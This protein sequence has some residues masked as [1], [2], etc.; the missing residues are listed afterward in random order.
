[1]VPPHDSWDDVDEGY[2]RGSVGVVVEEESIDHTDSPA[3]SK[4]VAD[5]SDETAYAVSVHRAIGTVSGSADTLVSFVDARVAWEYANLV[6]HYISES[7]DATFAAS[8]LRGEIRP[9]DERWQP[10]D[11]VRE[12][13]AADA[14]RKSVGD[15]V[16]KIDHVLE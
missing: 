3:G 2:R 14:I 12:R 5:G 11:P 8:E 7:A 16:R 1:M 9:P 10:E 15:H 4:T 13:S 6:T